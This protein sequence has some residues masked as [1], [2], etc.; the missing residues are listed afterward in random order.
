MKMFVNVPTISN[1]VGI[2]V[3]SMSLL[4]AYGTQ[5]FITCES[6][7][8]TPEKSAETLNYS[9]VFSPYFFMSHISSMRIANDSQSV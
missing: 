5:L 4:I 6:P 2:L 7:V 9:S 1:S 3:S 8:I